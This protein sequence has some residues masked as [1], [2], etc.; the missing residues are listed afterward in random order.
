MCSVSRTLSGQLERGISLELPTRR[1]SLRALYSSPDLASLSLGRYWIDSGSLDAI[2]IRRLAFPWVFSAAAN[3]LRPPISGSQMRLALSRQDIRSSTTFCYSTKGNVAGCQYLRT[4]TKNFQVGGE[5]YYTGAEN[6]GGL[7]I[8]ARWLLMR[9]E[10]QSPS[11]IHHAKPPISEIR[12][13]PPG[14]LV[15]LPN[16]IQKTQMPPMVATFIMNPLMGHLQVTLT[17][18]IHRAVS[19]SVRYDVNV[20]SF[21]SDLATGLVYSPGTDQQLCLRISWRHG[22][23]MGISGSLGGGASVK[24]GVASGPIWSRP[25]GIESVPNLIPSWSPS[26]GFKLSLVH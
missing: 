6:S 10:S 4:L 16:T 7:S 1:I 9:D 23:A 21:D 11:V 13:T 20:H 18:P 25:S 24:V 5:L 14:E 12:G 22:L 17:S 26:I 8:G 19:A 3:I 15:D 2:H